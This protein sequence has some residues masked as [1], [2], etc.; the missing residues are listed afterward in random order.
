MAN[1]SSQETVTQI[2]QRK[3]T[4]RVSKRPKTPTMSLQKKESKKRS[5]SHRLIDVAPSYQIL[6]E[7]DRPALSVYERADKALIIETGNYELNQFAKSLFLLRDS[8]VSC[9]GGSSINRD[10]SISKPQ[11]DHLA[12]LFDFLVASAHE[13]SAQAVMNKY[14]HAAHMAPSSRQIET[15]S[16][17]LHQPKVVNNHK[18]KEAL[19]YLFEESV[20][21]T[22]SIGDVHARILSA[23]SNKAM[24]TLGFEL[25]YTGHQS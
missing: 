12:M 14:H 25:Q 3:P 22:T 15:S 17:H 2:T 6:E 16:P 23:R 7:T 1:G 8:F 21:M 13:F 4:I 20:T 10:V 18:D 19:L 24:S 11:A 9:L 5:K